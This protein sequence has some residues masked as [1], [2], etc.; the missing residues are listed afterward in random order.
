[1]Y[2]AT[3]FPAILQDK[4]RKKGFTV[5]AFPTSDFRQ[6]LGSNEEIETWVNDNFPQ[7]KFPMFTL[8]TL[9]ENPVFQAIRKQRPE[10]PPKW[11]FFKYLIDGNG[12]VVKAFNQQS[13]PLSL[14]DDI[15]ELLA[16]TGGGGRL[17]IE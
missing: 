15:E 12:Q 11:N 7:A 9:E 10:D 8:S 16:K 14:V 3:S 17:V 2:S 1:L 13:N 5:L 6:E 4:Y